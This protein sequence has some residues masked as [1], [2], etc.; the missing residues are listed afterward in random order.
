MLPPSPGSLHRD[1]RLHRDACAHA[2]SVLRVLLGLSEAS[3]RRE[4]RDALLVAVPCVFVLGVLLL[5]AEPLLAQN[6]PWE[7]AVVTVCKAFTGIIGR[8]L[9]LVVSSSAPA[10]CSA[11]A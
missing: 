3:E 1:G 9:A 6:N 8:G 4:V 7:K 2:L 11:P 10:S 5:S